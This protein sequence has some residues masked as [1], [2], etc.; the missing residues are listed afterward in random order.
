MIIL[1]NFTFKLFIRE[2]TSKCVTKTSLLVIMMN[3]FNN[4]RILR[5]PIGLCAINKKILIKLVIS[6]KEN[7]RE[8]NKKLDLLGW[9]TILGYLL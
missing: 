6:N 2:N 7:F 3:L 4:W 5:R 1:V 8:W 9:Q